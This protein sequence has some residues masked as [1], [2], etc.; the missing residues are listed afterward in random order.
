MEYTTKYISNNLTKINDTNYSFIITGNE[1][2]NVDIIEKIQIKSNGKIK[3]IIGS[4]NVTNGEIMFANEMLC[5]NVVEL[6]N[7]D[8]IFHSI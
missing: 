4:I 8:S 7:S 2:S 1:F 3:K 5:K 6:F